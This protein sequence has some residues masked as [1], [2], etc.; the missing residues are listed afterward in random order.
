[1]Q[2]EIAEYI[3][4]LNRQYQTEVAREHTYRPALQKLFAA[5]LPHRIASNEPAR[6]RC[7][8]PDMI[9]LRK[10]DNVPIAY[11]ETKDINDTDLEGRKKNKEQFERYKQSL[12]HILFT[13][14]LEFLRYE[15]A[16]GE[17]VERVCIA[18]LKGGK[19][20]PFK[21]NFAQFENII[22]KFGEASPQTIVSAVQLAEFMAGKARLMADVIE[23]ILSN[24]N[25]TGSL[26]ELMSDFKK[27]LIHDITPKK[28]AD[29][30]A[31]TIAYGMFAA[32]LQAAK[33]KHFSR[34]DVA[35]LIPKTNPFLRQLFHQIAGLDLDNRVSWIVDDLAEVFRVADM[36][37]VMKDFG[38]RTRQTDPMIYFYEK[39][40]T[41]YDQKERTD[42]G[43]WYTPPAAV[44][45]IVRAVDDILQAEFGLL[46][47]LADT[48][49]TKIT[50]Q[51]ESNPKEIKRS[52][53]ESETEEIE[54]HRVQILDPAAGTGAFLVE[55]V[56]QIH[57]KI[58]RG[59]WQGYVKDH[60]LPRLN[61]FEVLMASY[62]LAH[63][64]LDLILKQKDYESADGQRF[65]IY[66][67]NSLEERH[68]DTGTFWGHVIAQ[69]ANA[70]NN[71]KGNVP[72]MVVMGNPPYNG[73]SQNKGEW[74][75]GLMQ[76]YKK[77]P[78]TDLPLKERNSKWI[79]NDYC[80][81]LRLGQFFVKKNTEGILAYINSNSFIDGPIFRGMRRNLLQTFDKI[82]ILDLHGNVRKKEIT[83]DGEHDENIFDI[84]EGV[85]INIFIKTGRKKVDELATVFHFDLYGKR[86]EKDEFLFNNALQTIPWHA[87]KLTAP[88]YFFTA[89]KDSL[90]LQREYENGFSIRELFSVNSV[91][92]VTANDPTFVNNDKNVLLTNIKESFDIVPDKAL[93]QPITE[94]LQI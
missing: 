80:K 67:T 78:D 7:G 30:Y 62:T 82:Y 37:S 40:F 1:M 34:E 9:L 31:Q 6:Q 25:E 33:P 23:K 89:K 49:K 87:L 68:P 8:A 56:N 2:K 59:M 12:D 61:G 84:T 42:R 54:V 41:K 19:I 44:N 16:S 17:I 65:H 24:D 58:Q 66:L 10:E 75:M 26:A 83:P 13:D 39:F 47:G 88:Q 69:E 92:I 18:E 48:S 90:P 21:E 60:I 93:I 45:F 52:R 36:Q 51:K 32:R 29:V 15:K 79:N 74:I 43:V 57:E 85:S 5:M 77:E 46:T 27:I 11:V 76:D 63:L 64:N 3:T 35:K 70:A 86:D 4:E 94:L 14:Y 55:T 20:K 38:K 81:F 53:S 28:F 50:I 72:V 22:K 71:I 73:A 91:G